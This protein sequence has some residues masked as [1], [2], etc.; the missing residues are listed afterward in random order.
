MSKTAYF[1]FHK[2]LT[3]LY[4]QNKC[5][6]HEKLLHAEQIFIRNTEVNETAVSGFL[7]FQNSLRDV[8]F[9]AATVDYV[10]AAAHIQSSWVLL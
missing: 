1:A 9:T 5:L 8:C 7:S 6:L 10:D 4:L 3:G 2:C